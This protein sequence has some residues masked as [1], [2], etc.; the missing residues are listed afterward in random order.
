MS[1]AHSDQPVVED[2]SAPG[3]AA[4]T[5]AATDTDFDTD[6]LD[7]VEAEDE[8]EAAVKARKIVEDDSEKPADGEIA[9]KVPVDPVADDTVEVEAAD[10]TKVKV[11]A[12]LKDDF[13]R[14]ADYTRKTQEAA[15]ERRTLETERQTW[16][17]QREESRAALPEE[18]AKVAIADH[19][20]ST[21]QAEVAEF[22][23]IDWATWRAQTLAL[24]ADDPN[25]ERYVQYRAAYDAARETLTDAQRQLA[26]VKDELSAKE[27]TRLNE[28]T[29]ARDT[30]LS[31]ARQQTGEA[32]KAQGWDEQRFAKVA[33]FAVSELGYSAEELMTA[34]DPRPWKS[35]FEIVNLREENAKLRSQVQ[36]TKT[37]ETNLKAQ[38]SRPAEAAKGNAQPTRPRDDNSTPT[39]M[40]KRNRDVAA[41]RAKALSAR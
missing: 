32:L 3:V 28:Q 5:P 19:G 1:E 9:E 13:L 4:D 34:T 11:P 38:E 15:A 40:E 30:A 7:Y 25:R 6:S 8:N 17:Q 29:T 39:W 16:E 21:A 31:T 27:Q 24:P 20:L 23:K 36:K 35:T 10:G 37:A 12:K 33:A 41:K 26:A 14:H 22:E 18:Y 2:T